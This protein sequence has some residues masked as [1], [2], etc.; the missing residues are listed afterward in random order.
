MP[1][2]SAPTTAQEINEAS[3]DELLDAARAKFEVHFEPVT[4]D[5]QPFQVLQISDMERYVDQ[6]ADQAGDGPLELPFWAKLWPASVLLAYYAKRF[7]PKPGQR[8]LEMGAGVG[9]TG[10]VAASK[11][12]DTVISDIETDALIFSRANILKNGLENKASVARV[13]FGAD[14]E[15]DTLT[16]RFDLILGAEVLYIE[17]TYRPLTK[18][19]GRHLATGADAECVLSMSYTR[20]AHG[21]FQRAEK[22]FNIQQQV[23]GFKANESEDGDDPERFLCALYRLTQRKA[24]SAA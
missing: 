4:V 19:I 7:Q 16:D 15:R 21:F 1:E 23:M 9:L 2:V 14:K 11:G 18:F 20:K 17:D 8:A 3:L 12:Y 24:G 6:L 10:L 5:G 13:D 22:E